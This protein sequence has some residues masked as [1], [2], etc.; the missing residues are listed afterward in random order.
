MKAL[1]VPTRLR[2][3]AP[4]VRLASSSAHGPERTARRYVSTVASNGTSPRT[5]AFV[6]RGLTKRAAA[7]LVVAVTLAAGAL[8]ALALASSDSGAPTQ[9]SAAEV[10]AIARRTA[11]T[12]GDPQPTRIAAVRS[13]HEAAA[14]VV[15]FGETSG[16]ADPGEPVE[17]I[18]MYG[19]FA[20]TPHSVPPGPGGPVRPR[21]GW[22]TLILG[23]PPYGGSGFAFRARRPPLERLGTVRY[24]S[25]PS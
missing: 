13:T 25:A 9:R 2:L 14:H 22:I 6:D 10:L 23:V 8:V 4:R 7:Y 16:V 18:T 19:R 21:R 17:V 1:G 24:I 15:T 3:P 12:N 5:R 11:R 20:I